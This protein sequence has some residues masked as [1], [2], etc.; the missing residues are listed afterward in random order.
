MFETENFVDS[1]IESATEEDVVTEETTP[2]TEV[3]DETPAEDTTP[4]QESESEQ[5]EEQPTTAEQKLTLKFNH[6]TKEV[7]MEEAV[8]LAQKGMLYDQENIAE[9]MKW[10]KEIV[11]ANGYE[12]IEQYRNA[13][14]EAMR[15]N[16]AKAMASEKNIPE[17]VAREIVE[18]DTKI[19]EYESEKAD[20]DSK[21]EE[22][23]RL[24]AEI[25]DFRKAYP[26]VD[27]G[28]FPKEVLEAKHDNPSVPIRF[29]YAA[30]NEKQLVTEKAVRLKQQQN[31]ASSTPS[32]S[33]GEADTSTEVDDVIKSINF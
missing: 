2:E 19:E 29:L 15:T 13:V 14:S 26:D 12:S 33:S 17:D 10:L 27:V 24:I 3:N 21:A 20:R 23:E 18:R 25:D 4:T 7:S 1:V 6:E 30:Y 5:T 31:E 22:R 8:I 9:T 32:L 16:K 11:K 28:N